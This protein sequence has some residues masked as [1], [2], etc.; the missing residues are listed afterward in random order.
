MPDDEVDVNVING[1]IDNL[2]FAVNQPNEKKLGE[3]INKEIG[4][5][6]NLTN[7]DMITPFYQKRMLDWFKEKCGRYIT[8]KDIQEIFKKADE[9]VA[10]FMLIGPT[11]V[12]TMS[13]HN[14]QIIFKTIPHELSDF[15]SAHPV[16]YKI[17]HLETPEIILGSI[18]VYQAL[19]SITSPKH[20]LVDKFVPQFKGQNFKVEERDFF[21]ELESDSQ[22]SHLSRI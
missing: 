10:L 11:Y 18:K 6:F 20:L 17:Y 19:K 14:Y 7:A 22:K 13:L 5:K 21:K 2:Y 4:E 1:F 8:E 9:K 15:L 16:K 12:Q 3:L